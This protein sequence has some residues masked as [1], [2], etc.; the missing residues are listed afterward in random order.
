[1]SDLFGNVIPDGPAMTPA[2][3]RKMTRRATVPNG[4]ATPPGT[5]PEG[6][7]CRSCVHHMIIWHAKAY[8]KC[9]LLR[10]VWTG[11]RATDILVR[12][13]ACSKWEALRW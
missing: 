2:E 3:R 6:E 8:H 9:G 13:P 10:Q 7:T 4:Y 11:G 1:M 5:G 12:S